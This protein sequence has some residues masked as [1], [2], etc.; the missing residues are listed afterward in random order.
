MDWQGAHV[1][2]T[3][4]SSGIGEAV[5]LEAARRRARVTLVARTSSR[6]DEAASRIRAGARG[7]V[8]GVVS[9]DVSDQA[10][11]TAALDRA[12]AERGPVDVLVCSA[13]VTRPGRFL[14]LDDDVFR[15][16]IDIDYYGTLWPVRC[17]APAMVERGS[18]SIVGV[19]SAAG[20][21]GV[22]GYSAYGAAKFAVRGLLE[23]LRTELAPHGVHVG[24]AYPPDV[25]TPML[26]EE[27][28]FKPA[29]TKAIAGAIKPISAQQVAAAILAG[30][31][32]HKAEIYADPQ[33]RALARTVAAAPA[34]YRRLFD[35]RV[36]Q[37]PL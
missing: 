35:R 5:A 36:R 1:V 25:D 17:V 10:A 19:S 14:E 34:V 29:E 18:G 3:G 37:T 33:T 2:V 13:G 22:Y 21:V 12:A 30:I 15:S 31:D 28:P 11:I 26:A 16:M 20:L 6:L 32:G 9:A 23:S 7:S 27:E 24:C 4:G 8:V